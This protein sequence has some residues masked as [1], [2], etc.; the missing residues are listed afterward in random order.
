[1]GWGATLFRL[2]HVVYC[3]SLGARLD[4]VF[5]HRL[6]QIACMVR[7]SIE[8]G[9]QRYISSPT[10]RPPPLPLVITWR[11]F[12]CQ[13]EPIIWS[14]RATEPN[15]TAHSAR[16]CSG[17]WPSERAERAQVSRSW[18]EEARGGTRRASLAMAAAG[19]LLAIVVLVM[20]TASSEL[21][22]IGWNVSAAAR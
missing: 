8:Q 20:N 3:P 15:H 10:T 21:I 2:R 17:R 22:H 7:P 1:M 6:S 16:C 13:L 4:A 19:W 14:W 18:W 5:I 9:I 11:F 12:P